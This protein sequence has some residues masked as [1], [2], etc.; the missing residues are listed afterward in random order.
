VEIILIEKGKYIS[1]A[2]CGLPYYIGGVIE[3]RG[4][5][6]VMT[7]ELMDYRFDIDIRTQH[8]VLSLDASNKTVEI[9]N[10][11]TG[12]IYQEDFTEIILSPGSEPLKPPI[13]GISE[14]GIFTLWTIPDTDRIYDYIEQHRPKRAVVVGG[15]FIGLEM[16]ENLHHKG[17]EVS[18]VE[19]MDQVMAPVD[20]DMAQILHEHMRE[21]GVKLHLSSKVESS[22]S[23]RRT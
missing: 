22:R 13:P 5:L 19:M 4:D 9:K 10:L 3:N 20:F 18:V 7:P 14:E 16:A 12:E 23:V 6:M 2:N 11:I 8:E 15:G 1:Y 21:I 17:I